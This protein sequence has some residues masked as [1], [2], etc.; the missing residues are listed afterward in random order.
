[1]PNLNTETIFEEL[2]ILLIAEPGR[3]ADLVTN[4]YQEQGVRVVFKNIFEDNIISN[5]RT[6]ALDGDLD[7]FY[8]IAVLINPSVKPETN[9]KFV[10]NGQKTDESR[11]TNIDS[12]TKKEKK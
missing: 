4:F 11:E 8:K 10:N 1:M 5:L 9:K 2:K 3:L 7:G 12:S 6:A